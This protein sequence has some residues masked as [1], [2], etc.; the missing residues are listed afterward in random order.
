MAE[1][2]FLHEIIPQLI[3]GRV[4]RVVQSEVPLVQ[5][6]YQLIALL[7][8]RFVGKISKLGLPIDEGQ[9]LSNLLSGWVKTY[10]AN[11]TDQFLQRYFGVIFP[12]AD[13]FTKHFLARVKDL[14]IEIAIGIEGRDE[15]I[16]DHEEAS[17]RIRRPL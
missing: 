8:N 14:S 1:G 3:D 2:K 15:S 9:K 17:T 6:C 16:A 11:M 7:P 10:R 4:K 12:F 5:E 13:T